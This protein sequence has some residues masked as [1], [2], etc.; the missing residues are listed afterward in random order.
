MVLIVAAPINSRAP[1]TAVLSF[2]PM[3]PDARITRAPPIIRPRLVFLISVFMGLVS[4]L[5]LVDYTGN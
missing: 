4:V 2:S 3:I 1:C 5:L